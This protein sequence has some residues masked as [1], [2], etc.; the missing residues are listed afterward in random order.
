MEYCCEKFSKALKD[1]IIFLGTTDEVHAI[2][3]TDPVWDDYWVME[4][5][6]CP[7][8]GVKL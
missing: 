6:Y 2:G 1:N 5:K 4:I 8:C 3:H 7:F